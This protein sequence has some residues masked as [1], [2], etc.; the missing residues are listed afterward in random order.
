MKLINVINAYVALQRSL[1]MKFDSAEHLLLQFRRSMG[2][3]PIDK[4]HPQEVAVFLQGKGQLSASWTYRYSVL[5]GFYRFAIGRGYVGG[6]PLPVHRPKLPP[7]QLPYVYS[8]AELAR[9]IEATSTLYDARSRQQ[10]STCRALILVLYGSGMRISEALRL[11]LTDVD[12]VQRVVTVRD[13]KFFKSRLVPIGPRLTQE[14]ALHIERRRHLP[15]PASE[16]SAVFTTRSGRPLSYI[17][18]FRLFQRLR[19]AAGIVCPPGEPRPPRLHDLRHTAAVHRLLAWYRA[20]KD[21]QCLLPQLA[22]YL[23]H[24]DI[25]STQ[26]YLRMTPE[27]LHEASQRFV[28]YALPGGGHE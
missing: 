14:L 5:S 24:A 1:G 21:V 3:V 17:Y 4:V 7:A 11:T 12:L 18:V 10:A 23:G 16:G 20:G 19:R 25:R 9:L 28:Q 8:T 22:T 6:S 27:L 15:M 2:N 13:T 26:P